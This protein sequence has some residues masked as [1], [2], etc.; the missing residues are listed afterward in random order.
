MPMV[1]NPVP[2]FYSGISGPKEQLFWRGQR[3]KF[4]GFFLNNNWQRNN[5]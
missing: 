1:D 4:T 3:A 5:L 2:F